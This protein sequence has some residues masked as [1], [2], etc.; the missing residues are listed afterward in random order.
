MPDSR[1]LVIW[2]ERFG[3]TGTGGGGIGD[4]RARRDLWISLSDLSSS[5]R[6]RDV[7]EEV[8]A[9][10]VGSMI[11]G[12]RVNVSKSSIVRAVVM[13]LWVCISGARWLLSAESS[14]VL[15]IGC[16]LFAQRFDRLIVGFSGS[17]L[18]VSSGFLEAS[19]EFPARLN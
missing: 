5:V 12:R 2:A 18:L 1:S 16:Y 3:F 19:L 13:R 9:L 17:R 6:A 14:D 11:S 8:M 4:S 7:E 15:N 10:E